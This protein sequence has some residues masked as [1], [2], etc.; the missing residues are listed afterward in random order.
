MFSRLKDCWVGLGLLFN[1]PFDDTIGGIHLLL[2][3]RAN[4]EFLKAVF[5]SEAWS[6]LL[7]R[8][9]LLS[10]APPLTSLSSY[11]Y[12]GSALRFLNRCLTHVH[13]V[14][15]TLIRESRAIDVAHAEN[16]SGWPAWQSKGKTAQLTTDSGWNHSFVMAGCRPGLGEPT[17][18]K[19][20]VKGSDTQL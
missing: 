8:W 16:N 15:S 5:I 2:W 11:S 18:V 19:L 7:G 6:L 14:A 20:Y 9:C 10:H 12:Q 4:W 17:S 13:L 1:W 3:F